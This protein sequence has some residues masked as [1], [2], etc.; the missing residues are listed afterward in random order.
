MDNMHGPQPAVPQLTA[1]MG[2]LAISSTSGYTGGTH[3]G[4]QYHVV[5]APQQNNQ[6]APWSVG[7]T[8]IHQQVSM[9]F[10]FAYAS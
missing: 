9:C 5:T 1:Q 3:G 4:T 10:N 8:H 2:H 6:Y 7:G